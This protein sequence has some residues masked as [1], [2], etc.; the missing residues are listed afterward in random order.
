[1]EL[2]SEIKANDSL[3]PQNGLDIALPF[4]PNVTK[5]FLKFLEDKGYLA[6]YM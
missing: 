1:M 4:L 6:K 5:S 3:I 2:A